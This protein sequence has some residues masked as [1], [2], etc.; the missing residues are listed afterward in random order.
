MTKIPRCV[1]ESLFT[2]SEERRQY[3]EEKRLYQLEVEMTSRC[4][5]GCSYCVTSS[6]TDADLPELSR[7]VLLKLV[8]EA[9]G[10]GVRSINWLG[11]DPLL[12]PDW[13]ELVQYSLSKG[14]KAGV[15]TSGLISKQ[16]ARMLVELNGPNLEAVGVHIDTINP[17]VYSRINHYPRTLELKIQGYRNLLEAGFPPEKVWTTPTITR[18]MVETI[19]E[20][21]DWFFDEMKTGVFCPAA[22]KPTGFGRKSPELE[23]SLSEVRRVHEYIARKKGPDWL[24]FGGTPFGTVYCRTSVCVF[25]E[26]DVSPCGVMEDLR[27]GNIYHKPLGEILARSR[28]AL[29]FI[30]EVEGYCGKCDRNPVCNGCRGNAYAYLGDMWASDPKCWLNPEAEEVYLQEN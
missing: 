29:L 2:V 6:D 1:E 16:Q 9:C 11:G 28:D 27:L 19:E 7:E 25:A 17:E 24:Q 30:G 22:F 21:V 5:A 23:P 8:D 4:A 10:I 20:T 13:F 26:G 12:H 14:M 18:P 3:M 15:M